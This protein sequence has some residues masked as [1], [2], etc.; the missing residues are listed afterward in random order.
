MSLCTLVSFSMMNA[1]KP[2]KKNHNQNLLKNC[3]RGL[4]AS[5][6]MPSQAEEIAIDPSLSQASQQSSASI[7]AIAAQPQAASSIPAPEVAIANSSLASKEMFTG[8]P[9]TRWR[10]GSYLANWWYVPTYKRA[11]TEAE[12]F[13]PEKQ[14]WQ[15]DQGAQTFINE[16]LLSFKK[17]NVPAELKSFLVLVRNKSIPVGN[18]DDTQTWLRSMD[19]SEDEQRK[20][21]DGCLS[22]IG[23]INKQPNEHQI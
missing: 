4:S 1:S 10:L 14:T 7:Q 6:I 23:M 15:N 2:R 16:A 9:S 21:I 12:S 17:H 20:A 3:R 22:M 19:Q 13:N 11:L 18:L 8:F 5:M